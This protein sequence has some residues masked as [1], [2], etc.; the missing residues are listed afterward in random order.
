[1]LLSSFLLERGSCILWKLGIFKAHQ[2][3]ENRLEVWFGVTVWKDAIIKVQ[4]EFEC[5]L[6]QLGFQ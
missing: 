2:D 3:W 1:M 4:L 5:I 6:S